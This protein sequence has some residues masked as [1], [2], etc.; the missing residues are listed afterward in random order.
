MALRHHITLPFDRLARELNL[1]L[2]GM[3]PEHTFAVRRAQ[4]APGWEEIGAQ[5]PA[6]EV[7]RARILYERG[8]ITVPAKPLDTVQS[9]EH[10]T[11]RRSS[12]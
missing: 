10:K 3:I 2:R 4:N 6:L 1:P 8:I 9:Q 7:R 5:V 11:K 12:K